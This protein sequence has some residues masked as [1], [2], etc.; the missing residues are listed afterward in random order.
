MPV[1]YAANIRPL[2]TDR[3]ITD[4]KQAP[5]GFD[6]SS[7]EQVSARADLILQRLQDGTMPCYGPWPDPQVNLFAQWITDGKRP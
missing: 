2:F 6:L 5:K 1:S 3:D 4:M 7:Y